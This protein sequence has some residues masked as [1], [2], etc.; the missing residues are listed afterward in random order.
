[1]NT[2]RTRR[3]K[4]QREKQQGKG[5][6]KQWSELRQG[7]SVLDDRFSTGYCKPSGVMAAIVL[8]TLKLHVVVVA[9]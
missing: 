1:M 3:W 7:N 5:Q 6:R 4:S 9:G 2:W 8:R